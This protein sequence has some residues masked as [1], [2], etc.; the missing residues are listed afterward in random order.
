MKLSTIL[1]A[2]L[3]AAPAAA[4]A[5]SM[6][7]TRTAAAAITQRNMFSGGG[8]SAAKED[9]PEAAKAI[10][11]AAK[12]MGMSVEEY[13]LGIN[14]RLRFEKSIGELRF[15]AGDDDIG[16]EVD[17]KSPPEFLEIII[18]SDGKAKGAEAI[19]NELKAAFAKTSTMGR[20][21]RMAAQQDMMKY[22]Q[23][24]MK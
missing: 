17:G 23:E 13:Q 2:T 12:A 18:S 7:N 9:D 1:I 24:Q 19:S 8:E 22:I 5:P 16:V 15:K 3:A 14:S 10:Q 21:G 11:E 6:M 20:E 4:F